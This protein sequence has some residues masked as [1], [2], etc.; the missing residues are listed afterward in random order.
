MNNFITL[1]LAT[2]VHL[3]IVNKEEGEKLNKELQTATLPDDFE[4]A[5]HMLESLFEKAGVE[6][7]L[8]PAK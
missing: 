4:A 7:K 5:I 1:F 6:S 2:L 8:P 3:G